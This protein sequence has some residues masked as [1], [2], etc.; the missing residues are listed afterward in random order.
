MPEIETVK[1]R[2]PYW[3]MIPDRAGDPTRTRVEDIFEVP[4]ETVPQGETVLVATLARRY[5]NAKPFRTQYISVEG[6]LHRHFRFLEYPYDW[7]RSKWEVEAPLIEMTRIRALD[8]GLRTALLGSP[9]RSSMDDSNNWLRRR[10]AKH[11]PEAR[12]AARRLL[13]KLARGHLKLVDGVLF[14]KCRPPAWS[15]DTPSCYVSRGAI[16]AVIPDHDDSIGTLIDARHDPREIARSLGLRHDPGRDL[17]EVHEPSL[18]PDMSSGALESF[19][20]GVRQAAKRQ[21]MPDLAYPYGASVD[22]LLKDV[23]AIAGTGGA[24]EDWK[25]RVEEVAAWR[26][27]PDEWHRDESG[28]WI[29]RAAAEFLATQERFPSRPATGDDIEPGAFLP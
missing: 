14:Q 2:A 7:T 19:C 6:A 3:A 11:S 16:A 26:D 12:D 15:I 5:N 9:F 22:A 25:Q 27:D 28:L 4:V 8:N 29:A 23:E 13:E 24:I 10:A 18:L 17:I 21:G 1:L 20:L